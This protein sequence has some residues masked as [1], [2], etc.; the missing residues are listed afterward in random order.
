MKLATRNLLC[1]LVGLHMIVLASA[2]TMGCD[3]LSNVI[4]YSNYDGGILNINVDQNIP[5]LKIGVVSYEAVQINI[6]GTYASNVTKVWYAGYNGT[7]DN[8]NLGVTNTTITGVAPGVDTIEIYPAATYPDA[9]GSP[10]MVC[11]FQCVSGNSGGCNTPEQVVHFFVTKFGESNFRFH[12]TLYNCWPSLVPVSGGG[13]CCIAPLSLSV[14]NESAQNSI[15]VF[16]NPAST[17]LNVKL[18][19]NNDEAARVVLYDATGAVVLAEDHEL[20]TG[21]NTLPLDV[22]NCATGIYLLHVISAS[23]IL[24]ETITID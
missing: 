4:I 21:E 17:E 6:T 9:S 1:T 18:Q 14:Q 8:C 3:S 5:N 23:G 20:H 2:Q 15:A 11:S 16:P 22:S 13:N 19:L 7:N 24:S 10:N 12:R